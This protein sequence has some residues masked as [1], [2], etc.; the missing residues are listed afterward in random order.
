MSKASTEKVWTL[1]SDR[2]RGFIATRVRDQAD[3]EDIWD[4]TA[5]RWGM[6]QAE[7][8]IRLLQKAVETIARDPR[9][10]RTC[11]DIRP[12]YR[13]YSVASHVLFYRLVK[14]GIDVVRVLHQ[15]MD[16]G[17]HL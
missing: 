12:G 16:F 1:F 11:D 15:R 17:Q 10:G 2:L 8:Y 7:D 14:D 6:G 13:K 9:R 3:I 5:E 4:Y